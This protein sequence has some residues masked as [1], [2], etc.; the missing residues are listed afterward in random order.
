MKIVSGSLKGRQLDGYLLKGTR[1][2][3]DRVKESLFAMIQD[4]IVDSICLDLFAG[5]GNLGI[6]AISQGARKVYF[7]DNDYKAL[8]KK[9]KISKEEALK[10]TIKLLDTVEE[11][12]DSKYLKVNSNNPNCIDNLDI[13]SYCNILNMDYTKAL[14][15]LKNI[16]FNLIFLDPPYAT[17]YIEKS[18]E[19]I[20]KYDLLSNDGLIVCESN[21]YN[22]IIYNEIYSKFKEKKYGDKWVVILRKI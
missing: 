2:T 12:N 18:I 20:E 14:E 6:E 21:D 8:V 16:K 22:K 5:S 9:L 11:V 7:N 19:L 1:P 3:M 13:K 4:Y 10:N 17:N 15:S